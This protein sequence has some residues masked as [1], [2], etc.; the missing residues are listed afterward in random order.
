[1]AAENETKSATKEPIKSGSLP[2]NDAG[3]SV[4]ALMR[5]DLSEALEQEQRDTRL[6]QMPMQLD[7]MVRVRA[8]RV[9]DLL[10]LEKGT[11]VETIH[12]HSQDVPAVCGRALLVWGEF[13]VMEQKL[14]VR[15]TRLA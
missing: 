14:A 7:V 8:L 13:E 9:E 15:I 12:H 4:G 5:T 10:R 11:V 1:M 3:E 2:A 6:D